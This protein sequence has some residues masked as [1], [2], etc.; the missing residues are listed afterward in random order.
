MWVKEKCPNIWQMLNSNAKQC[1]P[2]GLNEYIGNGYPSEIGRKHI[3]SIERYLVDLINVCGCKKVADAYRR[4]L[5]GVGSENQVEELFCEIALCASLAK[6]AQKLELRPPTGKGTYSDCRFNLKGFDIYGEVKRYGDPWSQCNDNN[7]K[8][9]CG[10][11]I[12]KAP[13]DK[14]PDDAKRPRSMDI[15]SKLRDVHKQLPDGEINVL[16]IFHSSIGQS[17]QYISQSLFGDSNFFPKAKH[18]YT[19]EKDGLFSKDK[20]QNISACCLSCVN[21]NSEMNFLFFWKNP[22]AFTELPQSVISELKAQ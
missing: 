4:D 5:S 14:K 13:P 6:H 12:F 19:L 18:N 15:R 11:P 20:W 21:Q 10:R 1:L 8:I 22:R 9:P 3:L 2:C 7:K 17:K 16:F